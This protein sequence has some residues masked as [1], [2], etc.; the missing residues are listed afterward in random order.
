MRRTTDLAV[1]RSRVRVASWMLAVAAMGT[2]AFAQE[3]DDGRYD[4]TWTAS[5]ACESGG[6]CAYR[7]VLADF[8]GTWQDVSARSASARVCGGRRMPLTVQRSNEKLLAFTVWGDTVSTTC[9]TLT[10]RVEPV[11]AKTLRGTVE[12]GVHDA[13]GPQA[14]AGHAHPVHAAASA[15]GARKPA[16]SIRLTRR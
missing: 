15:A 3:R 12:T 16:V 9:P 8:G 6:R 14:H 4:G 11:D 10:V 13:E 2:G 5:G 7:L 1:R